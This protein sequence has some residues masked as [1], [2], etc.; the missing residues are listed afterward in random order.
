MDHKFHTAARDAI[1]E[2]V[3]LHNMTV[4]GITKDQLTTLF[5]QL[6]KSGDI[7]KNLHD[8]AKTTITYEPYREVVALRAEV[9]RLRD[10]LD[11]IRKAFN[12]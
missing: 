6:I 7:T 3:E 9:N 11:I 5:F 12:E 1:G 8:N 4:E 2:I 10:K